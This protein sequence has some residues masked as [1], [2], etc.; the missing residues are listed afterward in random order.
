MAEGLGRIIQMAAGVFN[1]GVS[2]NRIA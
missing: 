1:L 2:E